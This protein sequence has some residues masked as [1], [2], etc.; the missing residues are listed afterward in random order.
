MKNF[1]AWLMKVKV[2]EGNNGKDNENDLLKI[3]L[4]LVNFLSLLRLLNR[5]C[6]QLPEPYCVLE[7]SLKFK[8]VLW[9]QPYRILGICKTLECGLIR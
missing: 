1:V 6:N 2:K 9:L 8:R 4:I 7:R 5:T 3:H